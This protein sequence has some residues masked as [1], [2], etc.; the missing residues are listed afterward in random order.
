MGTIE[1]HKIVFRKIEMGNCYF[2]S[3][4]PLVKVKSNL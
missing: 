2:G 3:N 1:I 4:T